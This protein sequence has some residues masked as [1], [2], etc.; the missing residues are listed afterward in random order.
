MKRMEIEI[1]EAL[2]WLKRNYMKSIQFNQMKKSSSLDYRNSYLLVVSIK[3]VVTLLAISFN[4]LNLVENSNYKF[5]PTND[6]IDCTH[7]TF[8]ETVY[9]IT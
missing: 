1:E 6:Y 4:I 5:D 3:I 8:L 2:V 9:I 7:K